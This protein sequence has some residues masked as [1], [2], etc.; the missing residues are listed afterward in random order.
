MIFHSF[1]KEQGHDAIKRGSTV[2]KALVMSAFILIGLMA[3]AQ[4]NA[5]KLSPGLV[6]NGEITS[7]TK[8]HT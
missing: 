1:R 3:N 4:A 6:W 2:L 7:L 8:K 5:I